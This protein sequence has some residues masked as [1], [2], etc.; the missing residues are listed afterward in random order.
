MVQHRCGRVMGQ[1]LLQV[2]WRH[3]LELRLLSGHDPSQNATV[4]CMFVS[5]SMGYA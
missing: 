5:A 4:Y 3:V 2:P 1:V